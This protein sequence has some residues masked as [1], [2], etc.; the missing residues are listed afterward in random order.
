MNK[1]HKIHHNTPASNCNNIIL[2]VILHTNQ[3]VGIFWQQCR[4]RGKNSESF[5]WIDSGV[6]KRLIGWL[7]ESIWFDSNRLIVTALVR[8]LFVTSRHTL[9]YVYGDDYCNIPI[10]LCTGESGYSSERELLLHTIVVR[11]EKVIPIAKITNNIYIYIYTIFPTIALCFTYKWHDKITGIE[12]ER[13]RA[14]GGHG[15]C[16][17]WLV[18]II[19]NILVHINVH[20]TQCK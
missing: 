1:E 18:L 2:F 20:D 13:E 3:F 11:Q 8:S 9:A 7:L 10:L 17:T 6:L 4:W 12:W 5:Q 16:V 14:G 15:N 19:I